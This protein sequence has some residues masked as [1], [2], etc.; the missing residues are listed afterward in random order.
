[1]RES[2]LVNQS[3]HQWSKK[4]ILGDK[5]VETFGNVGNVKVSQLTRKSKSKLIFGVK[6]ES[7]FF[8]KQFEIKI[9]ASK[10]TLII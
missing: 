10:R 2:Y 5:T 9:P 1:M 7:F 8:K 4:S 6:S 3:V